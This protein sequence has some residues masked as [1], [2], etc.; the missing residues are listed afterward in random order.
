MHEDYKENW[1]RKSIIFLNILI[2][3]SINMLKFQYINS[4]HRIVSVHKTHM[5][6]D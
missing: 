3:L 6:W 5:A 2:D 1:K 4:L